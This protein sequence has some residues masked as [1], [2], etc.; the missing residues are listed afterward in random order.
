LFERE[1]HVRIAAILQAL[2]TELLAKYHCYFGGGTAIALS[3]HEYRESV[4]IDF[5]VSDRAGYQ[6]MR[7]LMTGERGI[8]AIAR[9]GTK[10]TAV[11]EVRADQ[12]GIRTMLRVTETEIKF[13]IVLEGRINLETPCHHA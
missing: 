12:Y 1:H 9:V 2:D 11:K 3:H 10:L 8:Q 13:E 6:A 7:Q 4:D 5:M